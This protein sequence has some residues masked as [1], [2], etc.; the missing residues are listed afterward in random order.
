MNPDTYFNL[1]SEDY[2]LLSSIAPLPA[3]CASVCG[4]LT[5][6]RNKTSFLDHD[7]SCLQKCSA[8]FLKNYE[9]FDKDITANFIQEN[10]FL[11]LQKNA[12]GQKG[13]NGEEDDG[14]FEFATPDMDSLDENELKEAS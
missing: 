3:T 8:A 9:K 14:N 2:S 4:L 6:Q 11:G 12:E 13:P 10:P 5:A 7:F 1:L